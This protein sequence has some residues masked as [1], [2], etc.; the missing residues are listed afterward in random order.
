MQR[1]LAFIFEHKHWFLLVVLEVFSLSLF[2]GDGFYRRGLS[3]YISTSLTGHV[4]EWVSEGYA[5]FKL[6]EQNDNL[7]RENARLEQELV[8]LRRQISDAQAENILPQVLPSDSSEA[9]SGYAVARIVN[10][11]H[12]LG[13]V[14]YIINKG[15]RDGIKKDMPV[16]SA[17]GVMGAVLN[18]SA[19]Y[20][21]VIPIINP[22]LK[23]SCT[24]KGKGYDGQL[25]VNDGTT[26]PVFNGVPLHADIAT[27]DTL[28]TSGYSYIFPKGLMVGT[29]KQKAYK[30]VGGAS[31]FANYSVQLRTSFDGLTHV[32]VLL[33]QPMME[34]QTLEDS[35]LKTDEQ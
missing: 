13:E 24:V 7:L 32:Y 10:V 35:T 19:D 8:H 12:T 30:R 20:S 22:K 9:V 27:G 28:L 26:Q 17:Q 1:L 3:A 25:S 5:Y 2:L 29:I 11:R 31:P 18:C 23:L 34:A 21:I 6:S 15:S 33:T 16:M 14:Y 4:N